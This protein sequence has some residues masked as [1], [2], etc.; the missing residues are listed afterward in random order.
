M[1]NVNALKSLY[2]ALGG[3]ESAVANMVLSADVISAIATLVSS[4]QALPAVT[5]EDNGK[6]L[7]VIDGAWGVGTDAIE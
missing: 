2:T 5:A 7:K 4:Q 3:E 1:T 6:V